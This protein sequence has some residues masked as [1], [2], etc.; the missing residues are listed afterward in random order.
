MALYK[1]TARAE[2]DLEDIIRHTLE[3]WGSAQARRYLDGLEQRCQLLANNPGAGVTR[4]RLAVGLH[5]FPYESHILYYVK[6][7]DGITIV[8]VLHKYMDPLRHLN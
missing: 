7:S 2:A 5:S 6:Q 3:Q 4:D 8:R 1:F